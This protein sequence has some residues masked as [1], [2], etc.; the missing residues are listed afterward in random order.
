MTAKSGSRLRTLNYAVREVLG[1]DARS[2]NIKPAD[3]Q[4]GSNRVE[5]LLRYKKFAGPVSASAKDSQVQQSPLAFK[6]NVPDASLDDDHDDTIRKHMTSQFH[7]ISQAG[8]SELNGMEHN[9]AE[10]LLP[11][12]PTF[13]ML[14]SADPPPLV[15]DLNGWPSLQD[16]APPHAHFDDSFALDMCNPMNN[17]LDLA[18]GRYSIGEHVP[19]ETPTKML[20]YPSYIHASSPSNDVRSTGDLPEGLGL[21]ESDENTNDV[22]TSATTSF[23]DFLAGFHIPVDD[24]NPAASRAHLAS[25]GQATLR[26]N[27]WL[28]PED[29]PRSSTVVVPQ[30]SP[31]PSSNSLRS[32][33]SGTSRSIKEDAKNIRKAWKMSSV[34]SKGAKSSSNLEVGFQPSVEESSSFETTNNLLPQDI[35]RVSCDFGPLPISL[36]GRFLIDGTV[37]AE[38]NSYIRDGSLFEGLIIQQACK[39]YRQ[40]G[41]AEQVP[42]LLQELMSIECDIFKNSA[43]HIAAALGSDL[44]L[45]LHL[46]QTPDALNAVNSAGQTFVH[47][48]DPRNLERSGN[49]VQL[50]RE[51]ARK[52]FD[53]ARIDHLGMNA[54]QALL[55]WSI[56]TSILGELFDTVGH[57]LS[58]MQSKNAFGKSIASRLLDLMRPGQ[59]NHSGRE[60][61]GDIFDMQDHHWALAFSKVPTDMMIDPYK[62]ITSIRLMIGSPEL[63]PIFGHSGLHLFFKLIFTSKPKNSKLKKAKPTDTYVQADKSRNDL[64]EWHT[65][66]SLFADLLRARTLTSSYDQDGNTPLHSLLDSSASSERRD[67]EVLKI[68]LEKLLDAGA[69][70]EARNRAGESLLHITVRCGLIACTRVLIDRGANVHARM[71]GGKGIIQRAHSLAKGRQISK[72]DHLR[73]AACISRVKEAGAIENPD[74]FHEWAVDRSLLPELN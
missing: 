19:G 26:S 45:L 11:P 36:P 20:K 73:V 48:L 9:A 40:S 51:L 58:L 1:V 72:E 22:N 61:L 67:D 13:E 2:T 42:G 33:L 25:L 47:V 53:F 30:R 3:K 55:T 56:D 32:G 14:E 37:V 4:I 35:S 66:E 34:S 49:L 27:W 43:L 10:E 54:V 17:G 69:C 64:T 7:S 52:S 38:R 50:L 8:N 46:G 6:Y 41:H 65:Q 28:T 70:L 59:L 71:R 60:T 21:F 74:M 23:D 44:P 62:D 16:F 12:A 29:P 5:D 57:Q 18:N 63:E 24:T 68:Y 15:A 31:T 39:S